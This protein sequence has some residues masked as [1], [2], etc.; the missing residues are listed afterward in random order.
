M[1]LNP[2]PV[3]LLA[4]Q[5]RVSIV[6][7]AEHFV[8]GHKIESF[9]TNETSHWLTIGN[10]V[11]EKSGASLRIYREMRNL[12]S[13]LVP[14][15]E[16]VLWDGRLFI[17]NQTSTTYFC[18][19]LDAARKTDAENILGR[20]IMVS[21]KMVLD[22]TP[23]LC[24]DEDDLYLPFVWGFERPKGVEIRPVARAIEHFC[25]EFDASLLSLVRMVN[26]RI[27]GAKQR[28]V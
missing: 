4:V 13:I 17:Q 3:K 1:A 21:P 8:P 27:M 26:S 9:L 23:Y 24:G 16:E 22:S 25:P 7:G 11:L 10:S 6:G 19:P 14:P 18:G 12:P 5:A 15:G 20:K 2:E 28:D